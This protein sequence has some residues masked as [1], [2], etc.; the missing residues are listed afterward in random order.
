M[1]NAI[2]YFNSQSLLRSLASRV[3]LH[4]RRRIYARFI[5][6]AGEQMAQLLLR[7]IKGEKP[8]ALQVLQVP[9]IPF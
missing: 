4:T 1:T 9:E 5:A 7:R 3:A 2:D 6:L 8:E